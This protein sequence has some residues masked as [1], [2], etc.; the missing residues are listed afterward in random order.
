MYKYSI[1]LPEYRL[2]MLGREDDLR[3]I[4]SPYTCVPVFV[5]PCIPNFIKSN[6]IQVGVHS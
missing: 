3:L 4:S 1:E 2:F 5:S 6:I